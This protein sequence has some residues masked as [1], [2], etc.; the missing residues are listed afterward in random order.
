MRW[1]KE[2]HEMKRTLIAA[3]LLSISAGSALAASPYSAMYAFGDSLSDAGNLSLLTGGTE[4][5]SP[6]YYSY[7][8][9]P[10]VTPSVFSNGPVWVQDLSQA[11]GLGP[12]LP[13]L[14][15]GN[16][17]AFGGAKTGATDLY[18]LTYPIDLPYQI[19]AFEA[20]H[21]NP[22]ANVGALFTLSIG[23]NDVIAV[24]TAFGGGGINLTQAENI[25]G[26]AAA[27]VADSVATLETLG[28]KK[29]VLFDVP[30]LGVTP[31]FSTGPLNGWA[32]EFASLFNADVL[33]DLA[34]AEDAG[35]SVYDLHTFDLLTDVVAHPE[36]FPQF[37]DVTDPCWT[38][39]ATDPSPGSVCATPGTYL[40]WDHL[41]PTAT[42]HE[43]VAAAALAAIPEP[44]TRAMTLAGFFAV[45]FM[46]RVRSRRPAVS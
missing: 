40:F 1:L 16:D 38:G 8:V 6:P 44:S 26:E 46:G 32:T 30:N 28:A 5:V 11:L 42:G 2:G 18:P 24:L 9:A 14:I 17:F 34:P 15:G 20:L 45:A 33:H 41:H 29:L 19:G 37:T 7:A 12:L 4:P 36:G 22:A 10:G 31:A 13:S 27:N 43:L 21:S 25:I 35:L 3:A 39:N 23:A